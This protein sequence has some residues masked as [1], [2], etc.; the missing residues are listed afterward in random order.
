MKSGMRTLI[1]CLL[2]MLV[3]TLTGCLRGTRSAPDLEHFDISP[4]DAPRAPRSSAHVL[5]LRRLDVESPF[6]DRRFLYRTGPS[7]YEPDYYIRFVASPAELLTNRLEEWIEEMGL[8]AA[9]VEPGSSAEYR[10]ILEGQILQLYGDYTDPRQ[11]KAVIKAEFVLVDDQDG[12]GKILFER[13]YQQ[14]EPVISSAADGL[15]TG[16]GQAV[17]SVFLAL[18]SDLQESLQDGGQGE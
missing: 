5:M 17:R 12:A 1:A 7:T 4:G 10:Y 16:W 9:V 2:A 3:F 11:P 13:Q 14:A 8:F 15:A 18:G 6:E